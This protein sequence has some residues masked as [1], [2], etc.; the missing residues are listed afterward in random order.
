MCILGSHLAYDIVMVVASLLLFFFAQ[1]AV[2]GHK[3]IHTDTNIY[4]LNETGL[5]RYMHSACLDYGIEM[6]RC[7]LLYNNLLLMVST[8]HETDDG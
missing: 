2:N 4:G 8:R 1:L 6:M 3:Y 5:L 7:I